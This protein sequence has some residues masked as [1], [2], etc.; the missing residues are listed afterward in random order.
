M[1]PISEEFPLNRPRPRDPSLSAESSTSTPSAE[2]ARLMHQILARSWFQI[3]LLIA[4]LI[5]TAGKYGSLDMFRLPHGMDFA[6]PLACSAAWTNGSNP[7]DHQNLARLFH[8]FGGPATIQF[9]AD[10]LPPV[11]PPTTF[12]LLAPWAQFSWPVALA[13]WAITIL[14][15]LAAAIAALLIARPAR[16]ASRG[17]LRR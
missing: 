14:L 3:A 10:W 12:I 2:R 11:Y 7:Y 17:F 15:F 1:D 16:P 9:R 4:L 13:A 5:V 6:T 8:A